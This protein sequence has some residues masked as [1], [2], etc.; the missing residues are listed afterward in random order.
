M[1]DDNT[2]GASLSFL[3]VIACAFGAI[4]LLVLIIPIGE[5]GVPAPVPDLANTLGQLLYNVDDVQRQI[6]TI[7][8]QIDE[9][10][11]IVDQLST[12][13]ASVDQRSQLLLST[14][15]ST[16]TETQNVAGMT[17]ILSEATVTLDQSTGEIE[18]RKTIDSEVAGIPVDAEYVAFVVDT[19]GSMGVIKSKVRSVLFNLL[20]LYP[21][22]KGIQILN[23][24]GR[25]I[26]RAGS[27]IPDS[28]SARSRLSRKFRSWA[29]PSK[30][31][32]RLGIRTA[33]QDLYEEDIRMAVFVLGDD[34]ASSNIRPYLRDLDRI[35]QHKN[36]QQ[37]KLRVHAVAFSNYSMGGFMVES[38][39]NFI[40]VMRELTKRYDGVLV[41]VEPE[42]PP[43]LQLKRSRSGDFV[44]PG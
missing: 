4:V 25:Y 29:P 11:G 2:S 14:I 36:V 12:E 17:E 21:D 44:V 24:Q 19:S 34:Y 33:I 6:S 40:V 20:D 9:N 13:V 18:E 39:V 23:D 28:P 26:E 1:K 32:P 42:R 16:I 5:R 15:Q 43:R 41:A 3:D 30:S 27:W 8:H 31:D 10:Q 7:E 22:L 35:I 37:G 38:P